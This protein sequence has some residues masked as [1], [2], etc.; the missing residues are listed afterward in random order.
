MRDVMDRAGRS[1]FRRLVIGGLRGVWVRGDLPSGPHVYAANHH[2]WWDPFV[3]NAV[4][5]QHG[6]RAGLVM[7]QANLAAFRPLRRLAVVGNAEPRA[8][9]ALLLE[10]R[11]LVIFPEGTLRPAGAPGPL[12]DGA[13]WFSCRAGVQLIAAATR[14]VLRGQQSG[15]AYVWL[16]PVDTGGTRAEA[17]GR[18]ARTLTDRLDTLDAL[19]ATAEDPRLPLDG[20]EK[21]LTGR[22]SWDERLSRRPR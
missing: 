20:F 12:A 17:T 21:V 3:A 18:L 22:R 6:R 10:G 13:A 5:H 16:T 4:L 8:A 11:P 15:E 2:S 1:M 9:L 7:E 14:V 19:I